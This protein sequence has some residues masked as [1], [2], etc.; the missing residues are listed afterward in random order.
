M[1]THVNTPNKNKENPPKNNL[2]G[3][4]KQTA[5]TF[6]VYVQPT[7]TAPPNVLNSA[8]NKLTPQ[9]PPRPGD[10]AQARGGGG[11]D[12]RIGRERRG[13]RE[14]VARRRW[15]GG[16]GARAAARM[17]RP[18]ARP[19]RAEEVRAGA[20]GAGAGVGIGGQACQAAAGTEGV[21]GKW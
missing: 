11:E 20:D 15:K 12:A 19:D 18:D 14:G 2:R 10:T 5:P 1:K 16:G 21:P 13:G 8:P 3:T 7:R 6:N 9:T 17:V 4:L